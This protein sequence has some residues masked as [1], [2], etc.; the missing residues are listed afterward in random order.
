MAHSITPSR[1]IFSSAQLSAAQWG[2]S[3]SET[4]ASPNLKA[5]QPDQD[6][7]EGARRRST[8]HFVG[9]LRHLPLNHGNFLPGGF[10]PLGQG[11]LRPARRRQTDPR[12]AS[13]G[14]TFAHEMNADGAVQSGGTVSSAEQ[15][16][17][18]EQSL[19]PAE[20][21]GL[22]DRVQTELGRLSMVADDTSRKGLEATQSPKDAAGGDL[23]KQR[24]AMDEL[25]ER[26]LA[27]R[28]AVDDLLRDLRENPQRS[29]PNFA[30][31]RA[32]AQNV[33]QQSM[34][35]VMLSEFMPWDDLSKMGNEQRTGKAA[36]AMNL[37][38]TWMKD[39]VR[40]AQQSIDLMLN[41]PA[42]VPRPMAVQAA[43]PMQ[44]TQSGAMQQMPQDPTRGM[45]IQAM[46][47]RSVT[48]PL[49]NF[50]RRTLF[51]QEP[52][53]AMDKIRKAF[54]FAGRQIAPLQN[55][56]FPVTYRP[57]GA[58]AVDIKL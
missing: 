49:W 54:G 2:P 44:A 18:L 30:N 46:G 29:G 1:P 26:A 38:T 34:R 57:N 20:V 37:L 28:G 17:S 50:V 47:S 15:A 23:S 32:T 36:E 39:V 24:A 27:L 19:L 58:W 41:G 9:A 10:T 42:P 4:D 14:A 52:V 45:T 51:R 3:V 25:R 16:Q 11:N 13:L 8:A 12:N 35:A 56:N 7:A 6:E 43:Q 53:Q 33:E 22:I 48:H 55:G 21:H 5:A 31:A 40:E